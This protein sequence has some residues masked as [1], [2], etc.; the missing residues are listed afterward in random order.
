MIKRKIAIGLIAV[1]IVAVFT[2]GA[3]YA[4][5]ND[6][7]SSSGNSFTAGTL[8]LTVNGQNPWAQTVFSASNLAPGASGVSTMTLANSG[9]VG[10]TLTGTILNLNDAPGTTPEPEP[11]PDH[12]ELSANMQITVWVDANHN[13][14][15]DGTETAI[16]SGLLSGANNSAPWALGTLA[17]GAT[18]YVSISYL[19]PTTVGNVI[20]GDICTFTIEYTLTQT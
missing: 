18:T 4:Y 10:G 5:F 3:I 9:S 20:M 2:S 17:G 1:A 16:Y 6:T 13:G 11:T 7:E 19:I 12:G 14:V 15:I 8:D